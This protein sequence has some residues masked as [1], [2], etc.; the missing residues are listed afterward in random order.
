MKSTFCFKVR[1][2]RFFLRLICTKPNL[3]AVQFDRRSKSIAVS[4]NS[5]ESGR[6][7]TLPI[8]YVLQ[9]LGVIY[10]S[11]ILF[12][13]VGLVSV[14]VVNFEFRKFSVQV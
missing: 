10:V 8:S 1:V 2:V 14:Y 11:K 4:R 9:V 5:S 7:R 12:P 6:V 3:P 13:V